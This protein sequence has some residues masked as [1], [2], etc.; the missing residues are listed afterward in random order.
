ML[1][2]VTKTCS[3]KCK[4]MKYDQPNLS[5]I[6]AK[7]DSSSMRVVREEQTDTEVYSDNNNPIK[8]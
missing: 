5:I 7:L 3:T 8:P 4:S 6:L 1:F 2:I